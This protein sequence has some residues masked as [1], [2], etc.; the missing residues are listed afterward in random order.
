[1]KE[2]DRALG[3][4]VSGY[5]HTEQYIKKCCYVQPLPPSALTAGS[6]SS[7]C[8]GYLDALNS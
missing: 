4:R 6:C 2:L 3:S 7:G 1:V 5:G 8:R